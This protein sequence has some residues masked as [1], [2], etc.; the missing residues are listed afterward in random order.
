MGPFSRR[1][2]VTGARAEP[3]RRNAR[4]SQSITSRAARSDWRDRQVTYTCVPCGIDSKES[5][6]RMR[7][8]ELDT[9]SKEDP[10]TSFDSF[11][12]FELTGSP[13]MRK[14]DI[15]INGCPRAVSP[16]YLQSF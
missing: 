5:K 8:K 10:S 4:R 16:P 1:Y 2:H 15:I 12:C 11:E 3:V 6:I 7:S 9:Y 14:G 13:V